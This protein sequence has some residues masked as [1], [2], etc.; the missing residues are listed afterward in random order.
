MRR[1]SDRGYPEFIAPLTPANLPLRRCGVSRE[2]AGQRVLIMRY[3]AHG[4][5]LMASPLL[6]ALR[7]A[8]PDAHLTWIV[9]RKARESIEASPFL[10]EIVL[11]D[12]MYW[13]RMM[14]RGLY[15]LWL[16]RALRFRAELRRRRYDIFI[17]FQ[18]EDWPLLVRHCGAPVSI[19]VFDTFREFHR[20]T[21]TSPNARLY[22]TAYTYEDLP[23]HRSGH[24]LL[25]LRALGIPE[26]SDRRMCIGYT[27]EDAAAVERF[28]REHGLSDCL[29][30]LAPTAGWPSRRWPPERFA[31][32]ADRLAS[33][34]RCR[35]LLTGAIEDRGALEAV[36][37]GMRAAHPVL[38]A[39]TL[40]LR[41]MAALIHR[42]DLVVSGDTG[43]MHIAAAVGTPCVA[44]FG[45]TPIAKYAPLVGRGL[46]LA[47]PVP[48][49]PCEQ[50]RCP[51]HGDGHL[52][53]LRLIT[54]DE[55]FAAAR[56]LLGSPRRAAVAA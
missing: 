25:P 16:V 33:H 45:P 15:P 47:H 36:A 18:P 23:P 38:A 26:P 28:R 46:P 40:T 54:V 39:G 17:S 5:L 51:K 27:G 4:D 41:E 44:L 43:P 20:E 11:W 10:D 21:R 32:L 53:C 49:G 35:I 22:T 6:R 30:V 19:G 52:L 50:E 8:W 48:C 3:G 55:A 37:A 34:E 1:R 24:Y 42:A 12:S 7:D 29:V 56:R 9:E 31:D 13:K 14:R 2:A